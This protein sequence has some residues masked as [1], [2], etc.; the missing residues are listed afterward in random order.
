[1][2]DYTITDIV[3]HN[4]S[5]Y[6]QEFAIASAP[7]PSGNTEAIRQQIEQLEVQQRIDIAALREQALP[8]PGMPETPKY[9]PALVT[10]FT[11]RTRKP[12]VLQ[13]QAQAPVDEMAAP[14]VL[15]V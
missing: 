10:L 13:Q 2:T 12:P 8:W 4:Q 15:V 1:M 3:R 7:L 11:V 9:D 6:D 5:L 14:Q